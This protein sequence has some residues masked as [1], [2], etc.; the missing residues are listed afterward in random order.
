MRR[1]VVA[2][3]VSVVMGLVSLAAPQ[4][5]LAQSADVSGIIDD[6]NHMTLDDNPLGDQQVDDSVTDSQLPDIIDVMEP[7]A[8]LPG[9]FGLEDGMP[10]GF[11]GGEGASWGI[12]ALPLGLAAVDPVSNALMPQSARGAL[13]DDYAQV[14]DMYDQQILNQQALEASERARLE[15]EL[16]RQQAARNRKGRVG[17][18][19]PFAEEFNNAGATHN[20]DP[21]MLAAVA[22][23]ES[24]FSDDVIYCRRDSGAG[25]K[26]IMQFMPGTAASYG[27]D[28]CDP[29]QAIDGGARMLKGLYERYG[30]WDLAFA[31]YNAGPGA[32]DSYNGVPPYP[33]TQ[34]YVQQVNEYWDEYKDKYPDGLGASRTDG[35]VCVQNASGIEVACHVAP[36]LDSMIAAAASQGVA[37]S[38][39][40]YRDQSRQ[41]ELRRQNCGTSDYDIYEKSPDGCSTPTAIPGTSM[42][43]RGEAVDFSDCGSRDTACFAWLSANASTFGFYNLPSEPWHWSTSGR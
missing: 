1:L 4:P 23:T 39:S 22:R 24:G 26:G 35:D 3:A 36:A 41:V 21:R 30:S 10:L 16:R 9:E 20:V 8:G 14:A 19:V 43:E 32:V 6:T 11:V 18:D 25:A 31:A 38:G 42:H 7:L 28:P 2:V 29:A 13:S 40:G 33:E 34:D 17:G 5:V 27:V 37:L 12:A 15:A